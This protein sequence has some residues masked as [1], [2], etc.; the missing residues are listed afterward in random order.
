[1]KRDCVIT[2]CSGV[3]GYKGYRGRIGRASP[4][5]VRPAL[6][7]VALTLLVLTTQGGGAARAADLNVPSTSYPTI[8]AALAAAQTGDVVLLADGAYNEHDLDFA[9]KAI[10]VRSVSD[11]PKKCIIDCQAMSRGFNF[12]S[13]ETAASVLRGITIRNGTVPDPKYDG[14][15][16]GILCKNNSSPTI[17]G[18]IFTGNS[19]TWGGGMSSRDDSNPTVTN[20]TFSGNAAAASGGAMINTHSSPTVAGCT[21]SGNT[22]KWGGAMENSQSSPTIIN[23][24]FSGNTATDNGGAMYNYANGNPTIINCILWG[25]T[26]PGGEIFNFYD[27][28]IYESHPTITYSNVQGLGDTTPDATTGNFS[29]DPQFVRSP[30]ANGATDFGDLHLQ[31]TSPCINVGS[32]AVVTVPP[33][34]ADGSG[35]PL[36]LDGRTRIVGSH[37][38]L[39]AYEYAPPLP[40]YTWSGFLSPLFKQSFKRGSTIP[41]KFALTGDSASITN[42]AAKLY[43]TAP[44]AA[45]ETL[46]GTFKYDPT[47]KQYVFTWNTKGW[48]AGTYTL[49]ADLGDGVTDHTIPV[50]LK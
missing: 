14:E 16:A 10:I 45:S 49:R 6:L 36:D 29:A 22:A 25:D 46:L 8:A 5:I 11:D 13:D 35:N 50:L 4:P 44:G 17:T 32:D 47:M 24:T 41:V 12:H 48:P 23:C 31:V 43:V 21:F 33:F 2:G 7:V 26:G 42:L 19:A 15:G 37:V 3:A 18:C 27:P 38:D 34:P 28:V 40:T 30:G 20:C 39:G 9:G 1:M